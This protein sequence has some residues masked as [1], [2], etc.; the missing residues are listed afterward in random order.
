MY[1]AGGMKA[2]SYDEEFPLKYDIIGEEPVGPGGFANVLR[3][4]LVML[5]LAK[6]IEEI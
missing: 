2:R 1:Y 4:V 6:E 3:T 5:D